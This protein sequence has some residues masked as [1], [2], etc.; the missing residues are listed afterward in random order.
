MNIY[1]VSNSGLNKYFRCRKN[2]LAF[3]IKNSRDFQSES[4]IKNQLYTTVSRIPTIIAGY[5]IK[6]ITLSD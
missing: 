5:R 2:V 6:K 4:F 1:E 3:L